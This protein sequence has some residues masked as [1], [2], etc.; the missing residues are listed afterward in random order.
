MQGLRVYINATAGCTTPNQS[1]PE[2]FYSRRDEGP[3]YRW[4]Y[5]AEAGRWRGARVRLDLVP[6][7][8]RTAQKAVPAALRRELLEHYL[9]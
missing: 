7:S 9:D 8:L 4:Q 1:I 2:V 5:A 6:D 3:Y